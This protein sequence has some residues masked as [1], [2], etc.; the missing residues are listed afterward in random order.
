MEMNKLKSIFCSMCVF[1][2]VFVQLSPHPTR[3][4]FIISQIN[5]MHTSM[6]KLQTLLANL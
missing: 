6:F 1:V 3:L 2:H 4:N 5:L